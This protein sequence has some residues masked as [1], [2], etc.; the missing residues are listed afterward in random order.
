M[1]DSLRAI[2][3]D[4]HA[5]VTA[6]EEWNRG[7][8]HFARVMRWRAT[9]GPKARLRRPCQGIPSAQIWGDFAA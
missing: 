5:R 3:P 2:L 4:R 8:E 9:S 1:P 6:G 7:K